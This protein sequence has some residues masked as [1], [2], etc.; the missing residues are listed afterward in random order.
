[1]IRALARTAARALPSRVRASLARWR[2]GH[3]DAGPRIR[4]ERQ[5]NG[6]CVHYTIDGALTFAA[7][8]EAVGAVEYH[9]VEDGD[10]RAEMVSFMAVSSAAPADALLLDV[11]AH[12]GLFSIV[13][14]ARGP[15][16]RAVLFEPSTPLSS[17]STEWLR[18]N[19]MTDRAE[20][21]CAGIGNTIQTRAIE[22]DVLGFAVAARDATSG[23]AVPFT[24]ID[25]VC[26]TEGLRPAIIK[27]DVEGYEA[28]VLEGAR[29]TLQ[30]ER[31]VLCLE[32]HLDMLEQRGRPLATLLGALDA[33]GYLF[34][35]TDGRPVSTAQLRRSLKAVLRVTARPGGRRA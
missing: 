8:G 7:V 30:R 20:T 23:T 24:T 31:P 22:T 19:H 13:H 29:E 6:T 27:I 34:E 17:G 26:C 16:H 15:A 18:L 14:L 3:D 2:F 1:M 10:S 11:G 5:H 35:T 28:E 4:I 25:H 12:I 21:R 32:L 9:F 33:A